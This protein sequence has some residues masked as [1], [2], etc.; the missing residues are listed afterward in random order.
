M[1]PSDE[2][3]VKW[4]TARDTFLG[5]N[6][7]QMD[8]V[9]GLHLAREVKDHV[10]EAKWLCDLFPATAE[11]ITHEEIATR[12]W[13]E[14][15]NERDATAMMYAT[16][17]VQRLAVRHAHSQ[18]AADDAHPLVDGEELIYRMSSSVIPVRHWRRKA[19]E[20][21]AQREP[22]GFYLLGKYDV[23]N[24]KLKVAAELGFVEAWHYYGHREFNV[25]DPQHWHWTGKAAHRGHSRVQ[26][27]DDV[28]DCLDAFL[29]GK[30][31]SACIIQI[32]A[33]IGGMLTPEVAEMWSDVRHPYRDVLLYIKAMCKSW[34]A[35]A[36]RAVDAWLVV[37]KRLRVVRD[38]RKMIGKRIWDEWLRDVEYVPVD[39]DACNIIV[40]SDGV[41]IP[42]ECKT[43]FSRDRGEKK[44]KNAVE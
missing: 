21:V 31:P 20:L 27:L 34:S 18:G 29:E 39:T 10:A 3:L 5:V 25:H 40:P 12:L 28:S 14:A 17:V 36:R 4:Y 32:N 41:H 30:V 13:G 19:K 37:G 11:D 23:D 24:E 2:V 33:M 15:A 42:A 43:I 9:K 26:Y 16:R 22:R 38:V 8:T 6:Y 7:T 35:D 1:L 44:V